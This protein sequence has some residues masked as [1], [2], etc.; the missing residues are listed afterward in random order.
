M[1]KSPIYEM[2]QEMFTSRREM[3]RWRKAVVINI[4]LEVKRSALVRTIITR[5]IGNM[6]VPAVRIRLGAL[7]Q[8]GCF[9]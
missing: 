4:M 3:R 2:V 1:V 8:R 6:R 7:V 5:P 9:G